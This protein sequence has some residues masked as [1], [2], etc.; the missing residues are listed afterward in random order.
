MFVINRPMQSRPAITILEISDFTVS[1]ENF[2]NLILA[3]LGSKMQSCFPAVIPGRGI[4]L[5]IEKKF[6]HFNLAPEN[7]PVQRCRSACIFER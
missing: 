4:S 7:G 5:C 2:G 3:L 1:Q 6:D